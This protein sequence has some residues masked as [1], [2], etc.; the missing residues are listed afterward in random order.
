MPVIT[1]SR[2]SFSH[3]VEVAE[4][5]A[6]KLGYD[7]VSREVL[8]E[9]SKDFNIPEID[10]FHAIHDAP[11]L[12]D[13]IFSRKEKYLAYIQAAI[14]RHLIKD[15][16]VYHG[17]AGHFFVKDI[18]HA[19]KIRIIAGIEER[20]HLVTERRGISRK[21]A[22]HYIHKLD[23]HRRKWG[24]QLYGVTTADPSLYDMVINIERITIDDAV[25]IICHKVGLPHFQTTDA[26]Q[27]KILDLWL[28]AEVK[29]A[30]IDLQPRIEVTAN[31]G[32]VRL[33]TNGSIGQKAKFEE[34]I[35]KLPER[36]PEIKTIHM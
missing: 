27:Q 17:F 4:K 7:C 15:R 23:E 32:N 19:L 8:I 5:V 14:L 29:A 20:I 2:G 9:V 11:T 13:N 6:Q 16:V 12:L 30:L 28:A 31:D 26:S 33:Q 24:L 22:I 18:A 34:E 1:I 25:Y 36:I 35:K 10:L 3:G 21:E